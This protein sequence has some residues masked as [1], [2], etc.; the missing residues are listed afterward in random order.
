MS[1]ERI[2]A[3]TPLAFN[4]S[5]KACETTD[6]PLPGKPVTQ[7]HQP[8]DKTDY[9]LNLKEQ[10]ENIINLLIRLRSGGY[11]ESTLK[12]MGYSLKHLAKHVDLNNA[13]AVKLFISSKSNDSYKKKLV[14]VYALYCSAYRIA[15]DKPKYKRIHKLPFVPTESDVSSLIGG[16]TPKYAT[17][18]QV[19]KETGARPIEAWAIKWIDVNSESNTITIN[20]PAK[21]SNARNVQVTNQTIAMINQLTKKNEYLFRYSEK[22]NLEDFCDRIR[23]K[24]Y[25]IAEKLQNPRIKA[26]ALRNLR[27]FKATITYYKT[28]DI[29][30]V[31]EILGHVSI[32]NTL[33]YTHLINFNE[34]EWTSAVAKTI[35]EARNLIES[36]FEY[37]TELDG[38]KLFKKRK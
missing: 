19:V 10:R 30:Y 22:S 26:I 8:L 5:N 16:L 31:K 6:L 17:F 1:E 29:L 15:F 34:N 3:V 14:D 7:T 2:W 21:G 32:Q 36:G 18:C 37:V 25:R 12:N 38:V 24:R 28:R 4:F 33:I 11:K 27:H 20:N 9:P 13:E 35:E 23:K